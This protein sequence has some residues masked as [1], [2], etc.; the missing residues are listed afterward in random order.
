MHYKPVGMLFKI[1]GGLLAGAAFRRLWRAVAG[2]REAPEPMDRDRRWREILPV[3]ALEGA[4]FAVVRVTVER[5]GATA[6]RRVTGY[7]PD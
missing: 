6:V 4:T 7:R 1:G 3:A 2:E 5:G